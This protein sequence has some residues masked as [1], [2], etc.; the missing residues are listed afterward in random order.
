MCKYRSYL[1]NNV[2]MFTAQW[3]VSEFDASHGTWQE[4]YVVQDGT[5][6]K[7]ALHCKKC[8]EKGPEVLLPLL[9][10]FF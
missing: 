6:K 3:F 2:H 8:E 7:C 1:R 9:M 4:G 5:C 10:L